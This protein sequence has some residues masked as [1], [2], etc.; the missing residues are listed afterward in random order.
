MTY[1][2]TQSQSKGK[3]KKKTNKT[4]T[5]TTTQNRHIETVYTSA[6]IEKETKTVMVIYLIPGLCLMGKTH[7][8]SPKQRIDWNILVL[9]DVQSII[10]TPWPGGS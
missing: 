7:R 9:T 4:T 5:T 6:G 8:Q 3:Q 2:G 1:G 10:R